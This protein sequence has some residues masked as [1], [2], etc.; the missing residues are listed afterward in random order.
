MSRYIRPAHLPPASECCDG[1]EFEAGTLDIQDYATWHLG[2]LNRVPLRDRNA[3]RHATRKAMT[4]L[5]KG[6]TPT[7]KQAI[8]EHDMTFTSAMGSRGG[9]IAVPQPALTMTLGGPS[10]HTHHTE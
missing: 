6:T 5:A 9:V 8:A 3:S 4:L 7:L 1:L 2:A 10:W